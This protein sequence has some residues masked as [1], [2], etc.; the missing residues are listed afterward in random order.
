MHAIPPQRSAPPP[1]PKLS[2]PKAK[3]IHLIPPEESTARSTRARH[4]LSVPL[5]NN[6]DSASTVRVRGIL[7]IPIMLKEPRQV[8]LV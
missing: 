1:Q 3:L 6:L 7:K 2:F 4:N 8:I 5:T